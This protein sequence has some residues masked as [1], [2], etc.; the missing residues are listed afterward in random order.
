ML[1]I[2]PHIAEVSGIVQ[3]LECGPSAAIRHPDGNVG[4]GQ[5]RND[6]RDGLPVQLLTQVV[7]DGFQKPRQGTP[8]KM[9]AS[10][11]PALPDNN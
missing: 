6:S 3:T 11:T 10:E 7:K 2:V 8:T 1:V 9:I 4:Q 5:R